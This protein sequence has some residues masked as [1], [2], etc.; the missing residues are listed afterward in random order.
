MRAAETSPL[1]N[2]RV[3]NPCPMSWSDMEGDARVRFCKDCKLNVYNLSDMTTAEAEALLRESEGR[4][5][6]RYFQRADGHVITRN[7]P[8]GV[9]YARL[10]VAR[11]FLIGVG[12]VASGFAFLVSN[13]AKDTPTITE[14]AIERARSIPAL[15]PIVNKV[16]TVPPFE[17]TGKAPSIE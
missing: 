12:V 15:T 3:A 9:A 10:K 16:K 17:I 4:L 6:V 7:C 13:K 8:K 2:L 14:R 1:H 5:C 11:G